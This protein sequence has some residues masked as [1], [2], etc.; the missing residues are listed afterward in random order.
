[1]A[2]AGLKGAVPILL[3]ALI[4]QAGISDAHRLYEIIFVV[5]AFSVIVQG[6]TLP[7]LIRQLGIPQRATEPEPWSLGIRFRH[8]PE[9][10]RRLVVAPGSA[11]DRALV[12]DLHLAGDAWVSLIIRDGRLL[13]AQ[14]DTALR[15]GDEA[16]LL[17]GDRDD[18]ELTALFAAPSGRTAKDNPGR[19]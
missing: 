14:A 8:E 18:R 19:P 12:G 17:A 13:P 4:V 10:L 9:G 16:V 15:A 3:G 7:W 11:A 1:V 5:V 2:W 6:S